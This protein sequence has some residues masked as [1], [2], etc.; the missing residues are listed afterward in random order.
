M[1]LLKRSR[2]TQN[3]GQKSE[4]NT[5]KRLGAKQV[6]GSGAMEG[7][8]GDLHLGGQLIEC[9]STVKTSFSVKLDQLRK[10]SSEAR[11]IGKTPALHVS[12]VKESGE[13]VKD[14]TWVMLREV[15]YKHLTD[16]V[17]EVA[18]KGQE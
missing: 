10:I 9:K 8:K 13:P 7:N 4:T 15:D 3:H 18:Q 5:A 12:F 11:D 2:A 1:G 6:A 17:Q 16:L 14:G